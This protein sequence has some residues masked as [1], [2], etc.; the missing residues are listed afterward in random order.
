MKFAQKVVLHC[1]VGYCQS[2][3]AMVERFLADGVK[4]VGVVGVDCG[5]VEDIVDALV[6]G[7]GSDATRFILTS[8]HPGETVADVV[9][10]ARHLLTVGDGEAQVVTLGG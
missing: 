2:L 5:R 8:S 3:D 10:F 4:F 6:V 7:D 1:P 9:E